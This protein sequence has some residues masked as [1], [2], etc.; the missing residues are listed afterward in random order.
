MPGR[1]RTAWD[2]AFRAGAYRRIR[3]RLSNVPR[4]CAR[5]FL[6]RGNNIGNGLHLADGRAVDIHIVTGHGS[7]ARKMIVRGIESGEHRFAAEVDHLGGRSGE[8]ADVR[9]SSSRDDVFSADGSSLNGAA[10]RIHGQD[11]GVHED[12]IGWYRS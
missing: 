12:L 4:A 7:G 2:A 6:E 3:V 5:F 11:D 1:D 8:L 10:S 9:R